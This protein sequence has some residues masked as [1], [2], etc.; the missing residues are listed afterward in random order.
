MGTVKSIHVFNPDR[1]IGWQPVA[2]RDVVFVPWG[3]NEPG[4]ARRAAGLFDAQAKFLP[5]GH[6]WRSAGAPITVPPVPPEI[7]EPVERLEGRWL[8]GGLFYAHFGHFLVESSTRLW[9]ADKIA[10]LDGVI[11]YPK[12]RMTHEWRYLRGMVPFLGLSGL[13]HLKIRAP[14]RPVIIDE[15]FTPPPGF[16]MG[17]MMAGRPEYRDW[18]QRALGR[19]VAPLGA[20]DIYVSRAHLP[21]KRG[22]IFLE[23]RVEAL[24]AEAGYH[25]FHPQELPLELQIAQWKAAKRIVGLDGSALHLA[26]MLVGPDTKV[27]LINRAPSENIIDYITQFRHFAG[28]EVTRIDALAGYWAPEGQ[29][30]VKREVQSRLDFPAAGQALAKA[31]FLA[32]GDSWTDPPEA[33]IAAE[34]AEYSRRMD[35]ALAYQGLN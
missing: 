29:P 13:G 30:L 3:E 19:D 23:T 33:E 34:V 20:E 35:A 32:D 22:S 25:I 5:E 9:A 7:D 11:F 18:V 2:H 28:V 27:A 24:M 31:G 26:A 10:D 12:Q 15:L 14:Q 21:T 6:C 4:G 1:P 17:E 16:G 8:F